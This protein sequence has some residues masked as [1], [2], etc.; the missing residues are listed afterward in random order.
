MP[1]FNWD[2]FK[3]WFPDVAR[4]FWLNVKLFLVCEAVILVFALGV[5]I[6][7]NKSVASASLANTMLPRTSQPCLT[8]SIASERRTGDGA[9]VMPRPT[10]SGIL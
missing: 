8:S 6:L 2:E 3:T 9:D 10:T 4:H 1:F 5:A 7:R